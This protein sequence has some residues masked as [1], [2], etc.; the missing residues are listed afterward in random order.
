M[1][2]A[3]Q[4]A[5]DDEEFDPA[6]VAEAARDVAPLFFEIEIKEIA[7]LPAEAKFGIEPP[8]LHP[9]G[10]RLFDRPGQ[11]NLFK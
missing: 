2:I 5:G 1:I 10:A 4:S 8:M 9:R 11:A 7:Q 6:A 3:N